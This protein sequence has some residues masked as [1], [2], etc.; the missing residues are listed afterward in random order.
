MDSFMKPYFLNEVQDGNS[1]LTAEGRWA[2]QMLRNDSVYENR[3][4]K[5]SPLKQ[6]FDYWNESRGDNL[7]PM[8]TLPIKTHAVDVDS[9]WPFAFRWVGLNGLTFGSL[10]GQSVGDV[11]DSSIAT[12]TAEYYM[13]AKN[14]RRPIYH[15]IEQSL[16]GRNR[17]YTQLMLPPIDGVIHY[18]VRPISFNWQ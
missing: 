15:H 13:L 11:D 17:E 9:D 2:E 10:L 3:S 16:G 4:G 1:V 8:G 7:D 5:A 12:M 18:T 14:H 6:L